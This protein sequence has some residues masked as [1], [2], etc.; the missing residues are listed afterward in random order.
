MLPEAHCFISVSPITYFVC[1]YSDDFFTHYVLSTCL[2]LNTLESLYNTNDS[3]HP[4][5]YILYSP[6]KAMTDRQHAQA[7]K[8]MDEGFSHQI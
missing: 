7:V 4:V 2:K 3:L 6:V 5:K 1:I 8:L